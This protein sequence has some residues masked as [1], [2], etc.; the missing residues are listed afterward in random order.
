MQLEVGRHIAR[1]AGPATRRPAG[2][3]PTPLSLAEK[4]LATIMRQR[5][6]VPRTVLAELL[7]VSTGTIAAAERQ[8]R[9]LLEGAGHTTGPAVAR[10]TTMDDFTAHTPHLTA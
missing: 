7:R 1:G 2:G 3:H 8:V 6:E 4:A 10:L 9:P 5:L